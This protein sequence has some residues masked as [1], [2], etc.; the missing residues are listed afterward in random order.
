MIL[1]MADFPATSQGTRVSSL[2]DLH[3]SGSPTTIVWWQEPSAADPKVTGTNRGLGGR[4][5]TQAKCLGRALS[6]ISER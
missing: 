2:A 6:N 3:F 1:N 4:I 5:S